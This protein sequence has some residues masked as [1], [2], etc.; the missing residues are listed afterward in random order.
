MRKIKS[1]TLEYFDDDGDR[2]HR[3]EKVD[4]WAVNDTGYD[5]IGLCIVLPVK[6]EVRSQIFVSKK[7]IDKEFKQLKT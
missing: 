5:G 4:M 1:R 2:T 7:E 3:N 6:K